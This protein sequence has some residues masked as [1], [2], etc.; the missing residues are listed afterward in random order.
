MTQDRDAPIIGQAFAPGAS[1]GMPARLCL[2]ASQRVVW[3]ETEQGPA[4]GRALVKV[5]TLE[6]PLGSVETRLC[7]PDGWLFLTNDRRIHSLLGRNRLGAWRHSLEAFSPRLIGVFAAALVGLWAIWAYAL[8]LLAAIAVW[9]TPPQMIAAIDRGTL[10]SF[11]ATFAEPTTVS[12]QRQSEIQDL[13]EKLVVHVPQHND[14]SFRLEFRAIP[15]VGPNAFAL[16]GGTMI[17]TDDMIDT[18]GDDRDL[19]AGVL[20]HEM[21]HVVDQ[22]GLKMLYRSVSLYVIF[23]LFAGDFGPVLDEVM[24]EG[25]ALLALVHSK[26]FERDAD[27]FALGLL[28]DAGISPLGL[29][30][31][32]KELEKYDVPTDW[33]STHPLSKDRVDAIDAFID[34]HK[35]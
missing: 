3:I 27:Q 7:L 25:H 9:L 23:A 32:F 18:F 1:R 6:A 34:A 5:V 31:F 16:P 30:R 15:A 22:H 20:A 28:H 33:M 29:R 4:S 11:D 21:G 14:H 19:I 13:F 26:R 17:M 12:A 35:K 8:P 2:N 24:V 10:N